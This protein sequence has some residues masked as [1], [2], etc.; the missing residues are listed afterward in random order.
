MTFLAGRGGGGGGGGVFLGGGG[1]GA[2]SKIR[3]CRY[4]KVTGVGVVIYSYLFV[5]YSAGLGV[6]C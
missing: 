4:E 2:E 5:I 3:L 6:K 1:G